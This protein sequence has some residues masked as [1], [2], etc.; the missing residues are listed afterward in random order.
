MARP[1]PADRLSPNTIMFFAACA[2]DGKKSVN[3]NVRINGKNKNR[4]ERFE[5]KARG[6]ERPRHIDWIGAEASTE[7]HSNR[8]A[9]QV[10]GKECFI[11]RLCRQIG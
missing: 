10:L 6:A 9:Q 8:I 2:P 3:N 1:Y 7:Q 11:W 5:C 4:R